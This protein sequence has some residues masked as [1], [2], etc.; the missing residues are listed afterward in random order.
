M[1]KFRI[2]ILKVVFF[3]LA[4]I[5]LIVFLISFLVQRD[6]LI[7][8]FEN[9]QQ[10]MA[11]SVMIAIRVP[12]YHA[13]LENL[14][15]NL[16]NFLYIDEIDKILV[17][18][19]DKTVEV[20]AGFVQAGIDYFTITEDV[21][22]L[23][24]PMGQLQI[25]FSTRSLNSS[26]QQLFYRLTFE[27][28][29]L[30]VF[31]VI[32][33][34]LFS[35]RCFQPLKNLAETIKSFD[36]HHPEKAIVKFD[37]DDVKEIETVLTSFQNLSEEISATYQELEAY[38]ES[39][40]NTNEKLEKK[41]TEN[42]LL[43]QKLEKIIDLATQFQNINTLNERDFLEILFKN[44]FDIIDEADYGCVYLYQEDYVE[45]LDA[46]GHDINRLNHIKY[47]KH[48]FQKNTSETLVKKDIFEIDEQ[49]IA[50]AKHLFEALKGASKPIKETL[51]F[52]LNVNNTNIGGVSLDIDK[53]SNKTFSVKSIEALDAFKH[54][55]AAFYQIQRL[56]KIRDDFTKDLVISITQ[57][58]EIHDEYTRGHS[59][60]V[61][62]FGVQIGKKMGL[63]RTTLDQIYW[64]G[65][66]HDIGKILIPEGILNKAGKLTEEE[67]NIIKQ[68]PVWGH[69]TL[70]NSAKLNNLAELVLHH[71]ERWD[72]R[73]YPD[74]LKG[75]DI[76]LVSRIIC[77]ADAWDAMTSKRSYRK[78][79]SRQ[80]ALEEII[81]NAGT[82][83]D[84]TI[85]QVFVSLLN[86]SDKL[87]T[88]NGPLRL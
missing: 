34:S 49:K 80:E 64:T 61:A 58:L 47:P 2:R 50:D 69:K 25:D 63:D 74:G 77:V 68:H 40:I 79:L 8:H 48:L 28:A 85:S 62:I 41:N 87:L 9:I 46:K 24:Q 22:F 17:T 65:L 88:E 14:E 71:H 29:F 7:A 72:G 3:F 76:P 4:G 44:A 86:D 31:T 23:G 18:S 70:M 37:P 35:R 54:L 27:F 19:S 11:H 6:L 30:F 20:E 55:A 43:N 12:L 52:E 10:K 32:C 16:N 53:D 67:F 82:Q 42:K 84:P 5:F 51:F 59:E 38:N 75:K 78:P 81:K 26:V 57:M 1:R 15:E 66:V 36:L 73:G 13:N 45:F 56:T 21:S 60:S 83:F 39:L 33:F